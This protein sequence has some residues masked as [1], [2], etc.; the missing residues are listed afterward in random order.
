MAKKNPAAAKISARMK[1]VKKLEK[2][3]Y[4]SSKTLD[5]GI[6]FYWGHAPAAVACRYSSDVVENNMS[7][8]FAKMIFFRS[9]DQRGDRMFTHQ[10]DM[11]EI[12][13]EWDHR[14]VTE[15]GTAMFLWDNSDELSMAAL[16]EDAGKN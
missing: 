6:T 16:E 10:D 14:L 9:L 4:E 15:L 1:Y 8:A 5:N 11:N 2:K 12:M 3:P 7:S 13:N